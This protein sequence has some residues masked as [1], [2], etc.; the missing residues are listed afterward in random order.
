M[1]VPPFPGNTRLYHLLFREISKISS[2]ADRTISIACQTAHVIPTKL[3]GKSHAGITCIDQSFLN[4]GIFLVEGINR[5]S[6]SRELSYSAADANT[7]QSG[8]DKDFYRPAKEVNANGWRAYQG[9]DEASASEM[10][11]EKMT[12]EDSLRYRE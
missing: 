9:I 11:P 4:R 3:L 1:I 7:S 2:H 12:K 6:K 10:R 8:V 5:T